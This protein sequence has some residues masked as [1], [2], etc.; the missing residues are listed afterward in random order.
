MRRHIMLWNMRFGG[1][2]R[3]PEILEVFND[4]AP[5]VVVIAEFRNNSVAPQLCA[6][7]AAQG[8]KYQAAP[9]SPPHELTVLISSRLK[10]T[11]RTLESELPLWPYRALRA[12]FD[13][14]TI[15]GFYVPTMERKRPV[16]RW[17]RDAAPTL[18]QTPTLLIGDLNTGIPQVDERDAEL[19]CSAEFAEVLEAGWIDLY[20]IRNPESRERSFYERPWLGYRIDHALGSPLRS[21]AG[22][23]FRYRSPALRYDSEFSYLGQKSI[24]VRTAARAALSCRVDLRTLRFLSLSNG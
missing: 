8:L 15:I 9:K 7:L 6:G 10:F 19:T 18:L 16:L 23:P 13:S 5:D 3:L 4:H 2:S 1:G 20:H 12:D 17:M 22:H 21:T 14:F 24:S 11:A